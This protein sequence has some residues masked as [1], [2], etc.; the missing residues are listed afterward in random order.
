M[1]HSFL[2]LPGARVTQAKKRVS[3][4]SRPTTSGW[5]LPF[6]RTW[7]LPREREKTIACDWTGVSRHVQTGSRH[8]TGG[9][10]ESGRT[11]SPALGAGPLRPVRSP[12][13]PERC[14]LSTTGPLEGVP[15]EEFSKAGCFAFAA[16]SIGV[17]PLTLLIDR[18]AP[19]SRSS[20]AN[21]R[22]CAAFGKPV[23]R[24][25][26]LFVLRGSDLP[27]LRAGLPRPSSGRARPDGSAAS[28]RS[29]GRLR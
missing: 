12:Y 19:C 25:I 5:A 20:L 16:R 14:S 17:S 7:Q 2:N 1:T 28:R 15:A 18:S 3:F 22:P 26:T 8:D 29:G 10:R 4:V 21:S 13:K 24:C 11:P 9:Q 23:H 27:P 6:S